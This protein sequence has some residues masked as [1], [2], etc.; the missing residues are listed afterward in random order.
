MRVPSRLACRWAVKPAVP[1]ICVI[2]K[3][4]MRLGMHF[5]GPDARPFNVIREGSHSYSKYRVSA[6]RVA[7]LRFD[8]M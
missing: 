2:R 6:A 8:I 4:T 5:Q 7:A 3:L 1:V